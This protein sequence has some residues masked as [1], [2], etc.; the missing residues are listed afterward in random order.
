MLMRQN[1]N[2]DVSNDLPILLHNLTNAQSSSGTTWASGCVASPQ[3]QTIQ[4]VINLFYTI[5]QKIY[6]QSVQNY[7]WATAHKVA[8][9]ANRCL[10]IFS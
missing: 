1:V 4:N 6:E 10:E 8:F 7:V 9:L 5:S 3:S 2:N